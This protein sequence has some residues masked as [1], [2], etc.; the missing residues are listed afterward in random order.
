MRLDDDARNSA[1]RG[2]WQQLL[3]LVSMGA[4]VSAPDINDGDATALH[5]AAAEGH[6]VVIQVL[7]QMRVPVDIEK[8]NM[9]TP[10]HQA[11]AAGQSRAVMKLAELGADVNATCVGDFTPMHLAAMNGHEEAVGVLL[12]LGSCVWARDWQF[13]TPLQVADYWNH[14]AIV[15]KLGK[16]MNLGNDPSIEVCNMW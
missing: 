7:A 13:R 6:I 1:R 5:V 3:Q 2:N 4:N 12:A 15:H 16:A 8:S 10:L 9:R 11:A 14:T